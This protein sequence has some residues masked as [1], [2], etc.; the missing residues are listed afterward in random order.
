[1]SSQTL[2]ILTDHSRCLDHVAKCTPFALLA[3]PFADFDVRRRALQR[4]A[5]RVPADF[6][7]ELLDF[8]DRAPS[9]AGAG[10]RP[11][12]SR[13]ADAALV[14]AC[15]AAWPLVSKL[16][17]STC[18]TGLCDTIL[19]AADTVTDLHRDLVDSFNVDLN[20]PD[21][22]TPP[23]ALTTPANVPEPLKAAI[24]QPLLAGEAPTRVHQRAMARTHDCTPRHAV[25]LVSPRTQPM[26]RCP[27]HPTTKKTPERRQR[28]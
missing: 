24:T 2:G 19:L 28:A 14:G 6:P 9:A 22:P 11:A 16:L 8:L 13:I 3:A 18:P 1:M 4:E 17:G 15:T 21:L 23:A 10:A 20:A 12:V 5:M 7:I 26:P 25:P 27:L